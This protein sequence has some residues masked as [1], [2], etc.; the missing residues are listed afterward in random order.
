MARKILSHIS[1]LT[2]VETKIFN[3]VNNYKNKEFNLTQSELS[4]ITLCSEASISRFAKKYGFDNYRLFAFFINNRLKEIDIF[5]NDLEKYLKNEKNL[6]DIYRSQ[7]Y[8]IDNAFQKENIHK[9]KKV[10]KFINNAKRVLLFGLG[11]SGRIIAELAANLKKIGI[12]AIFESDFHTMCP[13]LGTLEKDDVII[14]LTKEL[15]NLEILFALNKAKE[16][17]VKTVVITS[18]NEN[19]LCDLID[20]KF[21]YRRVT[22]VNKL[23]P[24]GSK[25]SHLVLLDY[26]FEY[27]A[28]SNPIYQKKLAK[29]YK[30]L[31]D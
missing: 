14:C 8:A 23:V 27:I 20:I 26:L 24:I 17:Q 22:D 4:K 7:K 25:I 12:D 28:N 5:D 9:M 10:S 19:V 3:F 13:L 15:R 11:S 1:S 21:L 16:Y 6:L 29:A 2:N 31:N 18:N 30:V